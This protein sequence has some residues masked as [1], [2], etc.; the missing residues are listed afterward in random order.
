MDVTGVV[1]A[2]GMKDNAPD[3]LRRTDDAVAWLKITCAALRDAGCREVIVVLGAQADD[4]LA[5][6]PPRTLPVIATDWADGQSAALKAGLAAAATSSADAALI[7]PIGP[8]DQS[9][10]A[11]HRLIAAGASDGRGALA[12]AHFD[13]AP[14]HLVLVGRE[15][16]QVISETVTG[17]MRIDDYLYEHLT[18]SVDCTDL[19]RGL[20]F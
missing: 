17:S 12:R 3:A 2:A 14:G 5:L 20:D 18:M 7:L 13:D 19:R 9:A 8:P 4:A 6:V 10:P 1:I 11:G 16:W 15:H